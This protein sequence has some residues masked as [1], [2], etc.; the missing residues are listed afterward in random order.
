MAESVFRGRRWRARGPRAGLL[1]VESG[2]VI[3]DLMVVDPLPRDRQPSTAALVIEVA[4]PTRRH[5]ADK[6]P[7][8]A[9]A[10]VLE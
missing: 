6:A 4:V 7:R 8:Y 2:F 1:L 9:R 5:D 10:G 3:P